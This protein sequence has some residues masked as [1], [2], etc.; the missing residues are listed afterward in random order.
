M[1]ARPSAI[2]C[3]YAASW[4]SRRPPAPTAGQ[5]ARPRHGPRDDARR[6]RLHPAAV[7]PARHGRPAG[8][9]VHAGQLPAQRR[10]AGRRG[11]SRPRP[12]HSRVHPVR[13]PRVQ[14]RDRLQ[15]TT[16]RRHRPAGPSGPATDVQ[17]R[18]RPADRRVLLRIHRSRPL[19]PI[20]RNRRPGR[21]GQRR[22]AAAPGR[23]VR[24]P[25]P[26]RGRHDRPERDDGR[27]GPGDPV[28]GS[29]RPASRTSR[30]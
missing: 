9:L 7:R 11:R 8:N 12:G 13:H 28:A 21:R 17:E 18:R 6:P 29:T 24:Q 30:S 5:S 20:A 15:C 26:G 22:D 1:T 3:S 23:T 25:R 16:R 2:P 4:F 10:S 19:R 27:H 14:G